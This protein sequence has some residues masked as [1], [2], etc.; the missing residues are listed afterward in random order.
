M[1]RLKGER[2]FLPF[3]S[4]LRPVTE[5]LADDGSGGGGK[6][7]YEESR[8]LGYC[9][10]FEQGRSEGRATGLRDAEAETEAHRSE[11]QLRSSEALLA[12]AAEQA[13]WRSEAE[14]RLGRL[15]VA[16]AR[17]VLAHEVET[18]ADTVTDIVR[19]AMSAVIGAE[20]LKIRVAP[21]HAEIV[22]SSEVGSR[23]LEIVPDPTIDSGCV[24]E[25]T[26]GEMDAQCATFL[27][28]LDREAA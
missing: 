22:S 13:A 5:V 4:V 26:W 12:I 24:I 8:R 10:G 9:D 1:S 27:D 17:K 28:R 3:A 18:S 23:G 15:A 19:E 25:T 2:G 11:L 14:G 20:V 21:H 16:I 6:Q 7:A